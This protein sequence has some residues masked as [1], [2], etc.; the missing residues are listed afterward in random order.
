MV[1]FDVV[2]SKMQEQ[3]SN[4]VLKSS[5]GPFFLA[6]VCP[7]TCYKKSGGNG[8]PK[9]KRCTDNNSII[10]APCSPGPSSLES[11]FQAL[12]GKYTHNPPPYRTIFLRTEPIL[13]KNLLVP[14]KPPVPPPPPRKQTYITTPL[15]P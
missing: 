15:S 8:N 14:Q 2:S 1:H 5:N 6:F 9:R 3:H 10:L 11:S 7:H 13:A 4:K 12:F